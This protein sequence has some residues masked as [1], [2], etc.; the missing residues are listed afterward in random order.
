VDPEG[1]AVF[2]LPV[3]PHARL[4]IRPLSSKASVDRSASSSARILSIVADAAQ[5][6]LEKFLRPT[7]SCTTR[8]S[9]AAFTRR[10]S[11]ASPGGGGIQV[12][13]TAITVPSAALGRDHAQL[14]GLQ[15]DPLA[16]F[17]DLGRPAPHAGEPL[18]VG[19]GLGG[20]SWRV[21]AEVLLDRPAMVGQR[22]G[23]PVPVG[24]L[25][26]L[27]AALLILPEGGSRGVLAGASQL[28]KEQLRHRQ[29]GLANPRGDDLSGP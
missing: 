3:G 22:A 20:R 10:V 14:A 29:R 9:P 16:E 2:R 1:P 15:A 17:A 8:W 6:P 21:L 11:P 18:D 27:D 23:G 7:F 4:G 12:S 25:E 19:G 5:M 26:P 24:L 28:R 13:G